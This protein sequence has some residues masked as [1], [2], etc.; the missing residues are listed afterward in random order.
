MSS[1]WAYPVPESIPDEAVPALISDGSA[2]Y[3]TLKR[4]VNNPKGTIGIV[5]S[6]AVGQLA[7]AYA[8]AM[9]YDV[10]V[11]G[12]AEDKDA[13]LALGGKF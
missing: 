9:Q 13:I 7:L 12:D 5:G 4:H 11:L 10:T 1:D 6:K 3:S 2:I 8:K